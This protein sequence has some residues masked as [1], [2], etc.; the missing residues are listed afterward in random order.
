MAS[1]AAKV[2]ASCSASATPVVARASVHQNGTGRCRP[3]Q[4]LGLARDLYQQ[5][6]LDGDERA[7]LGVAE[8]DDGASPGVLH[9]L[10][11]AAGEQAREHAPAGR[12]SAG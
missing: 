5:R 10:V 11:G 3:E 2:P 6:C 1:R 8:L 4:P 9:Q 12:A 7:A